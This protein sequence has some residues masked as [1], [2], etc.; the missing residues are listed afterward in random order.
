[1]G[2]VQMCSSTRMPWQLSVRDHCQSVL[3]STSTSSG[4]NREISTLHEHA[5]RRSTCQKAVLVQ[6]QV[7]W[8]GQHPTPRISGANT[9]LLHSPVQRAMHHR[10]CEPW[11]FVPVR[12]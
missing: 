1:M 11:T 5:V 8:I 3:A 9:S 6:L 4:T 7:E 10:I 12:Q 2:E